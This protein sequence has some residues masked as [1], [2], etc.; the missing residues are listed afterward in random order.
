MRLSSLAL[1]ILLVATASACG[2]SARPSRPAPR[3]DGG[4]IGFPDADGDGIADEFEGRA[5]GIDTDSDGTPDYLDADSDNDGVP[6]SVEGGTVGGTE[7]VDT[8]AD[9][10]Y[11]FRDL[12]SDGNGVPDSIEGGDDADGDSRPNSRDLDN[13]GDN[14]SDVVEIGANP[15]SPVDSDGDG[16]EDYLDLD[17]DGDTISDREEGFAPDDTDS[18][19][20]PDRLDLDSDNDGIPDSTEAG[21]TDLNTPARDT[22]SDL[23]A[24]YRD[25]DS[26]ND[27]LSDAD[28]LLVGTNPLLADT[29]GDGVTDLVEVGACPAGDPTCASDATDP[30][31]SPRT[32]GDFVFFEPYMEAPDPLRDTLSFATDLRIADVYFLMDTTGSMGGAIASLKAGLSTPGTGLIDRV[33]AVIPDVWFGVGGFD[34]YQQAPYGYASS[35]DK[36]YYHLQDLTGDIPTAQA[37]VNLLATHYGGDGPEA[38]FPALYAVASGN[39][40]AGPSGWPSSRASGAGGF[41]ACAADRSVGWPCFRNSAVPIVVTITDI[42]SHNGPAGEDPYSFGGPTYAEV[43]GAATGSRIRA[44]GIAVSGGGRSHLE[45]MATATGAVDAAGTPL[46]SN[47]TIGTAI[48]DSVVSQI[49]TLANQTPIDIS[50]VFQDDASDAVDTFAAFVDHIEANTAG[51]PGRCDAVPAVDTDGDGYPDTFR[52]VRPGTPVCFD[53]IVKQNDTV[54]P[55]TSPQVFRANLNVLGDGFTPLDTREIFFLVPPH[56]EVPI[57]PG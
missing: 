49:Q 2:D 52:G 27:G 42:T 23:I 24:D 21:D 47:W 37:A 26:D 16:V 20:I 6:D 57:G 7:P 31:S 41:A 55:T 36:A 8:D 45:S 30:T 18:D 12:D 51:V 5:D 10:T 34:D 25:P 9:G 44:I 22:D 40:L 1:C 28:E 56:V 13:D 32:R 19:G 54:M 11:D 15:A 29:D 38:S 48:G 3:E 35:G 33:R 46:V 50:V 53:I 17:S 39:G 43:V 14:V 4:T